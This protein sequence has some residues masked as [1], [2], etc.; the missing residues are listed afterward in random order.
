MTQIHFSA[1]AVADLQRLREF[2]A[3]NNSEAAARVALRI[4]ESIG[5]L[6]LFPAKGRPVE[7]T[8]GVRELIAGNYVVRY[9]HL[10][11]EE[12][13]IILRVWHGKEYRDL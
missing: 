10:E 3:I 2:I 11:D 12:R 9:L 7:A 13:I 1:S 8:E 4:R 6:A 5:T